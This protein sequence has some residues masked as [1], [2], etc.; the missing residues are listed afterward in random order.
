MR[1]D[2]ARRMR[3]PGRHKQLIPTAVYNRVR[4]AKGVAP[5]LIV[6]FGDLLALSRDDRGD[7]GIKPR[8][9]HRPRRRE[10]RTAWP[11]V[12]AARASSQADATTGCGARARSQLAVRWSL[13]AA[14][15]RGEEAVQWTGTPDRALTSAARIGLPFH[16]K[17][18]GCSQAELSP[19]G[20]F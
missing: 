5:D 1:D 3:R 4:Q 15:R 18:H 12:I 2:L 6:V 7:E 17:R 13:Q 11:V 9:R 8:E 16:M 14:V 20:C 19:A 10:P